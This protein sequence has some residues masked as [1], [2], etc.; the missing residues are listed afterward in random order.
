[1]N[2][3]KLFLSLLLVVVTT[4]NAQTIVKGDMNSD[5]QVTIS[6]VTSLVNV[7]LGKSP[8]ETIDIG[9]KPYGVDNSM[10][11]GKWYTPEG[12]SFTLNEDGTTDFGAGF[13]YKF[14]P[15]QGTL[16]IFNAQGIPV[17]SIVLNEVEEEY[18]LAVDY[19]TQ[20]YVK[21]TKEPVA[22]GTHLYVDL[23]LPSGTLWATC[24]IGA[25]SPEDFGDYFAWGETET[26]SNYDWSTY[27]YCKG[28]MS[29]LTK[30]CQNGANGYEGFTDALTELETADDAACVLWGSKWRTPSEEQF[31][32]L[33]N[34][35]YTT[36]VWMMLNNVYGLKITSKKNGNY[37]FLPA[38]GMYNGTT[39]YRVGGMGS[40]MTRTIGLYPYNACRFY[41]EMG[42]ITIN[43]TSRSYGQP[44]RAVM[45]AEPNEE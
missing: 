16:M 40:Y 43:N 5:E 1:M 32:E 13:T 21:Y 20:T 8:V 17:R 39:P 29:T 22:V 6:D 34:G 42:T 23:G 15:Y 35:T 4:A 2:M 27:K 36:A 10:V 38:A 31:A 45:V 19:A 25:M 11:V 30:Y 12:T 3:R 14:R 7:I 28:T 41:F 33:L 9:G 24:N 18:L 26:K 37:I 44:V